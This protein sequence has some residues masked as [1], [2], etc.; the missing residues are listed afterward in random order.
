MNHYGQIKGKIKIKQAVVILLKISQRE[1]IEK[2][3]RKLK[4]G[5]NRPVLVENY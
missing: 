1:Y 4:S 2:E 3:V 5:Q